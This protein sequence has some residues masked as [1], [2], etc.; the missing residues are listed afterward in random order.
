MHSVAS[1]NST[2]QTQI[3]ST[4]G[5]GGAA[6]A[7]S[8]PISANT[9]KSSAKNKKSRTASNDETPPHPSTSRTPDNQFS[10][11]GGGSAAAT[12]TTSSSANSFCGLKFSYEA[13]PGTAA[14]AAT[15]APASTT[16]VTPSVTPQPAI[17][18]SPPSSPGS[19]SGSRKRKSGGDT[20]DFKIFQNGVHATHML[21]NQINPS[22]SVAQKLS[23]QLH[24][25]M[26]AHSVYT[27]SSMDSATQLIGIPFPGKTHAQVTRE[28]V[29]IFFVCIILPFSLREYCSVAPPIQRNQ[30]RVHNR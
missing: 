16:N 13:Q 21:G 1:N 5:S 15:A 24:M 12:P 10:N 28:L 7:A 2:S 23:D 18:D 19:E 29:I 17:K 30:R 11:I 4:I 22:S 27:S 3:N 6:A 26:E 8:A 9:S 20:K 14:A 25:E